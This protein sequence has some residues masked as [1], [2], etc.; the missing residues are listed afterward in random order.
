MEKRLN[1]CKL[2]VSISQI[3][4]Q[5]W[6][7]SK[8]EPQA[9]THI[10]ATTVSVADSSQLTIQ[11]IFS[12]CF[13]Y[14]SILMLLDHLRGDR[15]HRKKELLMWCV[16]RKNETIKYKKEQPS[17]KLKKGFKEDLKK[18]HAAAQTWWWW[19]HMNK[20]RAGKLVRKVHLY[21]DVWI[22]RTQ[23]IF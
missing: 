18:P 14:Y 1:G 8:P 4:K 5:C 13:I 17:Q 12:C 22:L 23:F 10:T 9:F 2:G 6:C 11:L 21:L 16:W 20:F 3:L 15:G 7:V 19:R